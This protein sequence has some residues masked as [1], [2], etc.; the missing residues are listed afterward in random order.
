VELSPTWWEVYSCKLRGPDNGAW[1]SMVRKAI[2]EWIKLSQSVS[3][4]G[5]A[6]SKVCSPWD[7]YNIASSVDDRNNDVMMWVVNA[8]MI[9]DEDDH[10]VRPPQKQVLKSSVV[11]L[12]AVF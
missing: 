6:K 5:Q 7:S 10:W 3:Y 2:G 8:G 9:F 1:R 11:T 12:E 4:D